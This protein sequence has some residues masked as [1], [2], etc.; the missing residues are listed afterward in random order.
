MPMLAAS[1]MLG[2]LSACATPPVVAS[3]GCSW[4]RPMVL[5]DD[6]LIVFAAN[7]R[8]LR[9]VTDQINSH[10]ATRAEKCS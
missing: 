3:N 10:N 9:P 2:L 8:V 1:T 6:E 4:T 5:N 7:I